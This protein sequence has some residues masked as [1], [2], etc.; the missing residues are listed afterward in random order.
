MLARPRSL[1]TA[2]TLRAAT[3]ADLPGL[4]NLF[5]AGGYVHAQLD[6]WSL[7]EWV[8]SPAFIVAARNGRLAGMSL[9]I[10]DE[11]PVA[12]W[13]AVAF[14]GEGDAGAFLDAIIGPTLAGLRQE[15]A[16]ALTC[17][18][19]SSWLEEAL[20]DLE[21]KRLTQVVTLRKDDQ[22]TPSLDQNGVTIR[23]IC[24][25]D[26]PGV[27]AVDQAAFDPTWRYGHCGL[28]RML[29]HN[30]CIALL[31][32]Q[33][34]QV[35]GYASGNMLKST[36]HIIRL[37]VHPA[38]QGQSVGAHLLAAAV[39]SFYAAGAQSVTLNTQT[40]NTVSQKLYRHF[41]FY[42]IGYSVDVWQRGVEA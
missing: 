19:F 4:R 5:R 16:A 15:G 27:L 36:G 26:V 32:E 11:S 9:A 18:A 34:G 22:R 35:I 14:D 10:H 8:G 37:A 13:R 25:T 31:A 7:D 20:P 30:T 17:L 24:P 28:S 3:Q 40:D 38:S 42:P 39:R 1:L 2:Y 33:D 41:D 21:F 6:W 23:P 12:W 29:Q